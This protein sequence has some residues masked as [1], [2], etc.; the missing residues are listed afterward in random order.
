[1]FKCPICGE[2]KTTVYA[3]KQHFY[4]LHRNLGNTC[5]LCGKKVKNLAM[6]CAKQFTEKGCKEHLGLYYLVVS[7][8][9]TSGVLRKAREVA[10]EVF[11]VEEPIEKYRCPLCGQTFPLLQLKEHFRYEHDTK[12]CYICN[13]KIVRLSHHCLSKW[14]C[15][16][17]KILYWLVRTPVRYPATYHKLKEAEEVVKRKLAVVD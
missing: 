3:L 9:R 6:H 13:R 11:K 10:E 5:P 1:M 8:Y 2:V 15:E 7:I 17:H 12:Y 14:D 4:C 16:E